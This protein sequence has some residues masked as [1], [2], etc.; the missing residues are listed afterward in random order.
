M[1]TPVCQFAGL[2][3]KQCRAGKNSNVL[4]Q[5]RKPAMTEVMSEGTKC[6]DAITDDFGV[7]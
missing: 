4:R 7:T 1:L 3:L 6:G 5:M 2:M